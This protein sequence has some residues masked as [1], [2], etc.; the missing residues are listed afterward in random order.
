MKVKN[1]VLTYTI[2]ICYELIKVLAKRSDSEVVIETP[3]GVL[4]VHKLNVLLKSYFNT[5]DF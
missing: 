4:G 2:S 3:E 1:I 5:M